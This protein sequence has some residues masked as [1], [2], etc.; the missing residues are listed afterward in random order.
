MVKQ[1][2]TPIL[3]VAYILL[4]LCCLLPDLKKMLY[5]SIQNK[6]LDNVYEYIQFDKLSLYC[7]YKDLKI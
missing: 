3:V 5:N 7:E 4:L 1:S 6:M 2:K